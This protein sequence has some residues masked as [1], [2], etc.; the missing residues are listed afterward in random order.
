LSV[1]RASGARR[2]ADRR[3]LAVSSLLCLRMWW[4]SESVM[5]LEVGSL[6]LFGLLTGYTLLAA[7]QWTVARHRFARKLLMV[8]LTIT[9]CR[10]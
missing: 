1:A 5:I 7:P 10:L 8:P 9:G 6:I 3:A 4:R 2:R